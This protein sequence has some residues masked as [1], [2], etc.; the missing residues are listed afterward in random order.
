[1]VA[2]PVFAAVIVMV[3]VTTLST[4]TALAWRIRNVG[5]RDGSS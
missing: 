1:V 2:P 4:P 3:I 5:A